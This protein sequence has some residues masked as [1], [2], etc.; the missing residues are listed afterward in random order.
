MSEL[1]DASKDACGCCEDMAPLVP[2]PRD[3][4]PG[5]SRIDARIGTQA[6][7]KADMLAAL[8]RS[9][10]L[11]R[12]T[13]RSD[14]DPT[15]A[16]LDGWA[17]VLDVL[18]FYQEEIVNEGYLRTAGERLSVGHMAAGIGYQLRPGV[19][20]ETC[21]AFE[22]EATPSTPIEVTI[23][24]GSQVQSTPAPDET[25]QIFETKEEIVGR[26]A[27]NALRPRLMEKAPV[28][29]L[30]SNIYLEGTSS[31]LEPGHALLFVAE[32]GEADPVNATYDLRWVQR[33]E[34]FTPEGPDDPRPAHTR[35]TLDRSIRF[36][37][38][39]DNAEVYAL[40]QRVAAFGHNAIRWEDLPLPLRVGETHPTTGAFLPGPYAGSQHNWA[41]ANYATTLSTLYLD[42][43]Y[44][45]L[46]KN[47]WMVMSNA[48]STALYRVTKVRERTRTQYLVTGKASRLSI[49]GSGAE[50]FTPRNLSVFCESVRMSVSERPRSAPVSGNSVVLN[51]L[52]EGLE[53]GR[54]VALTGLSTDGDAVSEV[55]TISAI[56]LSA[57]GYT[58]LRFE[59]AMAHVYD[60][61]S[62]RINANVAPANMGVTRG[63]VLGDGDAAAPFQHFALQAA[64]L[65]YVSANTPTGSAST[66]ELRVDGQL[67][68]E[69]QS[70]YGQ[71]TDARVYTVTHADDGTASVQFGDGQ[72]A[73]SR[74][75]SGQSN[76]T[77]RL[78]V[79]IGTDGNLDAMRIDQLASRPL[80]VRAV[81]NPVAAS[82]AADA[83]ETS[84]ARHNAARQTRLVDRI[85]TL[86]DYQDFAAGF[87]GIEKA[88]AQ[89]LWARAQRLIH[90]TLAGADGAQ[91]LPTT[92]LYD[93]LREA[94]DL[95]RHAD[96]P[97]SL[98]SYTARAF[99]LAADL[100]VAAD[101]VPEDV[102]TDAAA[103]LT[104]AFSFANRRFGQAVSQA[105]VISV[106]HACPGVEGVILRIFAFTGQSSVADLLPARLARHTS[107]GV[108][109]AELLLLDTP[110][111]DLKGAF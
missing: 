7:F 52:V 98:G 96:Q 100:T 1:K 31:G 81:L 63:E 42:Q 29:R 74:L 61:L 78:R 87:A 41:S 80:G 58:R 95:A 94:I 76:V 12:L 54:L 55:L 18:S 3:N 30:I 44:P 26:P 88:L 11:R 36:L 77:A 79:G 85:A 48:S 32:G 66:L 111:L 59:T 17:S 25:A 67:W 2:R 43:V 4:T 34:I 10:G 110:S 40:R 107:Q 60:R 73:G 49:S 35:V 103:Q 53:P 6:A 19:G 70:L 37:R 65:S 39:A 108:Q 24:A 56:T 104:E 69:V 93:N 90:I 68:E 71:G 106:L 92:T 97:V 75:P 21:L 14:D 8:A 86:S 16:V 83:E 38:A 84:E 105:E 5:K 15:I 62:L 47:S 23:P 50:N 20:S 9:G 99:T 72:T 57:A 91:V 109:A 82:G 13:T 45:R 46:V 27:W 22:C 28:R 51:S 33:L 64:P 101:R 102:A 89:T